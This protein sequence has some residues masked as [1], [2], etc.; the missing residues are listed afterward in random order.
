MVLLQAMMGLPILI[1][2]ILIFLA[3][4]FVLSVALVFI[5]NLIVS[6]F[7]KNPGAKLD[8]FLSASI[9]TMGV[10]AIIIYRFLTFDGPWIN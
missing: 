2:I 10:L 7:N 9:I 5:I 8:P 3:F 1:F 6:K 4:V